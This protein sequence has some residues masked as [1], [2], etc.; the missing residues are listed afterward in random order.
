MTFNKSLHSQDVFGKKD[1]LPDKC[2]LLWLGV[3]ERAFMDAKWEPA[4]SKDDSRCNGLPRAQ[5]IN[6]RGDALRWLRGNTAD[7][8][9]VC[10]NAGLDPSTVKRAAIDQ[11]GDDLIWDNHFR[12]GRNGTGNQGA[13]R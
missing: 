10:E 11:F 8:C 13:D 3:I 1:S 12:V 5:M 4:K 9:D 6:V 7:F 2:V